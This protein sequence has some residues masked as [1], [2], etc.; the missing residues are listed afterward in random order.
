[1]EKFSKQII[2]R[3]VCEFLILAVIMCILRSVLYSKIDV[4]LLE[5]IQ[6]AIAQQAQ[7]IA[8]TLNER[9]QH[10]LNELQN[11]AELL[12][13]GRMSAEELLDVATIGTTTGRTRGVLRQDNSTIAGASLPD[14]IFGNLE[15]AF[16]GEQ[17]IDYLHGKGLL[18][19]V[20][21]EYENETCVFYELFNDEAVQVFYKT[22]IYSGKGTLIL[23]K[24]FDNWIMISDGL[25]PELTT[26]DYPKYDAVRYANYKEAD[27]NKLKNFDETWSELEHSTLVPG[28]TNTFFADNGIDAFFFFCTYISEKDHLALS[29]YVEWDD[30]VVGLDYIYD[31]VDAIFTVMM[32]TIL[33][34]VGY[35]M[36]TRQAKYLEHEKIVADIANQAK[37]DFLS[38]MSHEIR[39]PI[40]AIL[41]MDEMILRES[42]EPETLEYARN[43]QHAAKSL[44]GLINDILD[45]S[46]IEAGKM[47]IIMVEYEI[48]SVLNDLAN[49]IK[50]RAEN[51]GL[52]FNIGANKNIPS[53]LFGDEI[54]IKQVITNILTN[55]VKYTEKGSVTL[56]VD[57]IPIDEE[58]IYLCISVTDTGIGIKKEDIKKLYAAFER[59]EEERN[60]TIEGTGLGM[61]I[62]NKLLALMGAEL[63]VSS[64]YGQGSN[65]SFQ[66]KQHVMNPEPI[67]DF[68]ER[69]KRVHAHYEEYHEK[70]TAPDA[71]ILVVDDTVMNLTVVKGLLKQTKIQIDTALNGKECLQ[72]V[73]AKKYDI[74]FIDHMMP[75]M[76]GIE[77]LKAMKKLPENLNENTPVISLTANAISG[78]REKYLAAGFTDYLTKPINFEQ[79]ETLIVEYLPD[80]KVIQCSEIKEPEV[81]SE[82]E[83]QSVPTDENLPE[84]LRNAKGLRTEAG[85]DH[86]GGV[87]NYLDVLDLFANSI[88]TAAEEIEGYFENKDWKNYTTK[89]HALKSTAKV[90]GADELSEKARRLENA[91]NSHYFNEIER[92]HRP[93]MELYLKYLEILKPMLN[94]ESDDSEKPLIDKNELAEAF[95]A[96]KDIS[97]SFDYD[98][99]MFIFQSLDE[100]RLPEDKAEVY[101]QIKEAAA[102]L[103]WTKIK[104]ILENQN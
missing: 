15:R 35:L 9:F 48:S 51:K 47:E 37:S 4:M 38:N 68:E 57:Y 65:F 104:E 96:M 81:K 49:M 92:D 27:V 98:S 30:A 66:I 41:G 80:E 76:D 16:E 25:Y 95:V 43:L 102:K 28:K 55:A 70:F 19:A 83:P 42:K 36:R 88:S 24:T 56:T 34:F 18:F 50:K 67:G 97:A 77:T 39:T 26:D 84:W 85:I 11:R 12:Q 13:N 62:T 5:E 54:R 22:I 73:Q 21:F 29:G 10:K 58:N 90:I 60:R 44:L 64:V 46:K 100:Y 31:F 78:A 1:M 17:T 71:K 6:G 45:L 7:S 74:I 2:L 33:I 93:L 79:L 86:C 20:P 23:A 69:Y 103:D 52:E 14:D 59:I 94:D 8:Y 75:G 61:N 91:G 32:I 63:R 40:N 87:E 82:T 101:R 53:S 89:V 99:L 3:A 72:M